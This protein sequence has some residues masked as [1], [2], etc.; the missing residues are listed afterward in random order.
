MPKCSKC[1]GALIVDGDENKCLNCGSR[2]PIPPPTPPADDVVSISISLTPRNIPELVDAAALQLG[3]NRLDYLTKRLGLNAPQAHHMA[4]GRAIY[5]K[6]TVRL[7][8]DLGISDAAF[9]KLLKA[10]AGPSPT[11]PRSAQG[12]RRGR[13]AADDAS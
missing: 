11:P 9:V 7:I 12:P 2:F 1:Q 8:V 6:A 13:R 3:L 10:T 5:P 4:A